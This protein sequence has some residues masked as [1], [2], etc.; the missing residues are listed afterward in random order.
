M[1]ELDDSVQHLSISSA[2]MPAPVE[3]T[4]KQRRK[5]KHRK[6]TN[7][8]ERTFIE[9]ACD[10]G[11]QDVHIP[12]YSLSA[13][14]CM[15]E[16]QLQDVDNTRCSET[17]QQDEPRTASA[18]ETPQQDEPRT[19]SACACGNIEPVQLPDYATGA[20]PKKHKSVKTESSKKPQTNDVDQSALNDGAAIR[21]DSGQTLGTSAAV[22][23]NEEQKESKTMTSSSQPLSLEELA[24]YSTAGSEV[25]LLPQR[26][27]SSI[28]PIQGSV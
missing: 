6:K 15:S 24:V 10:D 19:A 9:K 4:K 17:P 12:K 16:G 27:P 25:E 1:N 7:Q 26:N 5:G 21:H 18:C 2:V 8:K 11:R 28:M 14:G 13:D 22:K 23:S 3:K 20:I